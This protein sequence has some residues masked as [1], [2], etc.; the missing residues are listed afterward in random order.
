MCRLYGAQK[1]KK[2]KP[3]K[4]VA[5][6]RIWFLNRR[7]EMRATRHPAE[8]GAWQTK[9]SVAAPQFEFARPQFLRMPTTIKKY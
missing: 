4:T 8:V 5:G 7:R 3:P 2:N 9:K 6:V 1:I